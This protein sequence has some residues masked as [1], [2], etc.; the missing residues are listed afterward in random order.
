[1][2]YKDVMAWTIPGGCAKNAK[3]LCSYDFLI[4]RKYSHAC[5]SQFLVF[6]A[7]AFWAPALWAPVF[8]PRF[9]EP[10]PGWM[11]RKFRKWMQKH[12]FL[13]HSNTQGAPNPMFY[14]V[15]S[16]KTLF[17]PLPLWPWQAL[18]G[19]LRPRPLVRTL[20]GKRSTS[21]TARSLLSSKIRFLV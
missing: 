5:W 20:P 6:W 10:G 4:S 2:F 16:K 3:C 21:R 18:A 17:V 14:E 7:L 11:V 8:E 12:M 1:M 15:F 19:E 13:C 9:F